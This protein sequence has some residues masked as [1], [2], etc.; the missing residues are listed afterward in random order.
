MPLI[1]SHRLQWHG[2]ILTS[3]K[4][5]CLHWNESLI[6]LLTDES[7]RRDTYAS[8]TARSRN[9]SSSKAKFILNFFDSLPVSS[10]E[11]RRERGP[12]SSILEGVAHEMLLLRL[13]AASHVFMPPAAPVSSM[14][15]HDTTFPSITAPFCI[16]SP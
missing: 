3:N 8:L 2:V 14:L 10:K 13:E 9:S 12:P 16:G 1:T 6:F 15:S 7:H 4:N 11:M 5:L